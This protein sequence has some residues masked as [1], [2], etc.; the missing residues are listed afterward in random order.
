MLMAF[1][2]GNV[3]SADGMP[4]VFRDTVSRWLPNYWFN[5]AIIRLEFNAAETGWV[6][7]SVGLVVLGC[8]LLWVSSIR[9]TR[10]LAASGKT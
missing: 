10:R 2:G 4:D 5:Q 6:T 7:T 9:F 1:A 8:V 3:V